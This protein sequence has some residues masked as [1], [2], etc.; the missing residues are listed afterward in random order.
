MK[1]TDT[2]VAGPKQRKPLAKLGMINNQQKNM[3]CSA[4][5]SVS[6]K[7][8]TRFFLLSILQPCVLLQRVFCNVALLHSIRQNW[9]SSSSSRSELVWYN[10]LTHPI[11]SPSSYRHNMAYDGGMITTPTKLLRHG[12]RTKRTCNPKVIIITVRVKS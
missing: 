6:S 2:K 10:K 1:A 3:R 4:E 9:P 12:K 11:K 5:R 8:C 7:I